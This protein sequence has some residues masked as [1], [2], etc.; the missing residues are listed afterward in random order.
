MGAAV[1]VVVQAS[2]PEPVGSVRVRGGE[3]RGVEV[4][5][6]E[7]PALLDEL[8]LLAVAAA[9]A[10]GRTVIRGGGG[11]DVG[12]P[13]VA[14]IARTAGNLRAMGGM[15]EKQGGS[16]VVDGTAG[17]L[18]HGAAV[19]AG[20]DQRLALAFTVAALLADGE[21]LLDGAGDSGVHCQAMVDRAA[22]GALMAANAGEA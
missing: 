14:R 11:L 22:A 10:R 3:L 1:D 4:D 17:R 19:G 18:L 8:P 20:E 9:M 12:E 13:A 5:R 15:V 21:S 7:L 2:D 16:L 6:N